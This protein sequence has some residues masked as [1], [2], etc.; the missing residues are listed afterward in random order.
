LLGDNIGGFVAWRKCYIIFESEYESSDDDPRE[1]PERDL[2][3]SPKSNRES[4]PPSPQRELTPPSPPKKGEHH[5]EHRKYHLR[6][7]IQNRQKSQRDH[8]KGRSRNR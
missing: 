3:P 1:S 6:S 4:S 7:N 2:P 5:R 8:V